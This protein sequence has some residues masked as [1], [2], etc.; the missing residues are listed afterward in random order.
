MQ[1]TFELTGKRANLWINVISVIVP[2]VVAILLSIQNKFYFGEWTRSIPHVIG[3]INSITTV[4]LIAGLI[5]IKR[6]NVKLHRLAMSI[7]FVLGAL[8]LVLYVIYHLSN[9]PN[10]FT[11]EGFVRYVYFFT[12]ITHVAFS[13][14]VLPLVLRAMF[15]ALTN[16]FEKHKA[17]VKYAYPI[18]LYVSVTGVMVYAFVNVL[19]PSADK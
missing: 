3:L 10:K 4:S 17:I 12:L 7:S 9:P 15:F 2:V 1:R 13:L 14:V 5:F 8:F 11:G 6:K 16:Q 19:Y 18:W